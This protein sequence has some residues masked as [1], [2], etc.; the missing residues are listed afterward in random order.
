[1]S[2]GNSTQIELT[3][4]LLSQKHLTRGLIVSPRVTWFESRHKGPVTLD[5]TWVCT[6][7]TF[8]I[9]AYNTEPFL[10]KEKKKIDLFKILFFWKGLQKLSWISFSPLPQY[11]GLIISLPWRAQH[12]H[13]HNPSPQYTG[14]LFFSFERFIFSCYD[15]KFNKHCGKL[16]NY[17]G[18]E[19]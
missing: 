16:K 8:D 6:P 2:L 7:T 12:G 17:I 5:G 9:T 3:Q 14:C 4:V 13:L 15:F 11:M 18:V 10:K 1:M 19:K